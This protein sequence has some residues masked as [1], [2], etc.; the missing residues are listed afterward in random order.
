LLGNFSLMKKLTLS[1][2]TLAVSLWAADFWVAKPYTEWSEKDATKLMK[3]SPWAKE[4]T[5]SMGGAG[6]GGMDGGMSGG[7]GGRNRGGAGSTSS[8]GE[9]GG[10]A[11]TSTS[12]G[13]AGGGSGM[14]G[15]DIGGRG[16]AS[17]IGSGMG[18][19]GSQGLAVTCLWESAM[20]VKQAKVKRKYGSE[21]GTSEAA[22]KQLAAESTT[23]ILSVGP[24]PAALGNGGP[25]LKEALMQASV[26]NVKGKTAI[27]PVQVEVIAGPQA[28][29][30][31]FAFP[32]DT[33]L[34]AEDGEIEFLSKLR[35]SQVKAKFD[36]K[37][38]VVNGKL[39]M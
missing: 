11:V 24:F 12:A 3:S 32:K 10:G 36:L 17:D 22:K 29:M 27:K 25:Q 8:M 2:L 23:Y 13:A 18:G 7:R 35:T 5:V 1:L 4:V 31:Y 20:V 9:A 15:G 19:G 28:A 14:G 26:L 6:G 21:A 37:K 16:S 30:F 39:D 38:M 34:T 33:P